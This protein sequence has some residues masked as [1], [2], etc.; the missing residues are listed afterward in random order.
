MNDQRSFLFHPEVKDR[1]AITKRT[2]EILYGNWTTMGEDI[3]QTVSDFWHKPKAERQ[4][5]YD[6]LGPIFKVGPMELETF[7]LRLQEDLDLYQGV[8]DPTQVLNDPW[9]FGMG[10]NPKEVRKMIRD[11]LNI[12]LSKEAKA[13][14]AA[15]GEQAE[16]DEQI[17]ESLEPDPAEQLESKAEPEY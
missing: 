2:Y 5:Y 15:E 9:A 7:T 14:E 12:E 3:E 16:Q 13:R 10:L 6:Q 1:D 4:S 17:M 8:A 11:S